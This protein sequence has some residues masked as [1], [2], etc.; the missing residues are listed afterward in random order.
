RERLEGEVKQYEIKVLN[1]RQA[2]DEL[3]TS[4]NDLQLAKRRV[5]REAAD[6]KQKAL[7]LEREVERLRS[8]L[9]R[10][11]SVVAGSPASSPRK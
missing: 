6:F 10:P 2:M 1:M 7:N 11:S 5:E 9:D 3:Q 8:R 4:E